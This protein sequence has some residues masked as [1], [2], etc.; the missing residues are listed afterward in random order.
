MGR[1]DEAVRPTRA[2]TGG[3]M[4]AGE[5]FDARLLVVTGKGGTGKT[6]VASALA[7]A[8][9]AAGHEVL[10][11]EVEGRQGLAR[12]FD[13]PA[14]GHEESPLGDRVAGI[15]VEP[16]AAL[17]EYLDRAGVPILGSLLDLSGAAEL[18]TAAT[19]GL[20]DALLLDKVWEMVSRASVDGQPAYDLVILDAPPTGR[21]VPFL[22]APAT[23]AGLARVGPAGDR[24]GE[25]AQ[26]LTDP[27]QTRIVLTT[28]AEALP[29]TET[30]DSAAA[31]H[32][33]GFTVGLVVANQ[34]LPDTLGADAARLPDVASDLSGLAAAA[35]SAGLPL[36]HADL[37]QLVAEATDQQRLVDTQQRLI[38]DI[39][40]RLG[41]GAVELPRRSGGVDGH[42]AVKSLARH[43]RPAR[44][45]ARHRGVGVS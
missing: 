26:L 15:A 36:R 25:V 27:A 21:I 16:R 35:A 7:V 37:E 1:D 9:V 17:R 22:R 33:A 29:V 45:R 34:V 42:T 18:V 39:R 40:T 8:A 24:A 43:L 44:R 11:V 5:L 30:L 20:G 6:T 23:I 3:G 10:L 28:L 41:V 38:S 12:L 2:E 19:P 4:G 14:L 31:L 13:L 32:D